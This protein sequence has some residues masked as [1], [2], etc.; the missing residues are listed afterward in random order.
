MYGGKEIAMPRVALGY[1]QITNLTTVQSLTVPPG[2]KSVDLEAEGATIRFRDD[3]VNPTATVGFPLSTGV[4]PPF[5]YF[6]N[7]SKLR[8]IQAAPTATLDAMFYKT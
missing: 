4:S 6:G 7:L 2:A 3:G 1:Q 8:F 5:T